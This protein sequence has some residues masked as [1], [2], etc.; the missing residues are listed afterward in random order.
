MTF[1]VIGTL[2]INKFSLSVHT[3]VMGVHSGR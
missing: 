1:V 3:W 2:R